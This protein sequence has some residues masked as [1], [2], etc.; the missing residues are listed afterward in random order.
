M[1]LSDNYPSKS[2]LYHL[3]HLLRLYPINLLAKSHNLLIDEP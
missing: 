2:S 1:G 3:Y